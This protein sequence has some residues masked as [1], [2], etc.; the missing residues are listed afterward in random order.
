MS[1]LEFALNQINHSEETIILG[2]TGSRLDHT[3]SNIFL[4]KKYRKINP[5]IRDSNNEIR[6]LDQD[7]IFSKKKG[8][9]SILPT[10]EKSSI[11]L[12][13]TKWEL[14]NFSPEFG[15]TKTVSNEFVGNVE[16]KIHKGSI[17]LFFS[18]D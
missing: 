11:S 10:D 4:L 14:E 6:Y 3:L 8:Y 7:T 2:P 18:C 1:D 5:V 12:I 9:I 16:I 17:F 15:S 13:G